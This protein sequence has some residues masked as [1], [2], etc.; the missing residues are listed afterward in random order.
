MDYDGG[1]TMSWNWAPVRGTFHQPD[2]FGTLVF[3]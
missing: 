1:K 2:K 3:E